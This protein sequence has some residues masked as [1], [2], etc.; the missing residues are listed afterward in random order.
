MTCRLAADHQNIFLWMKV[1]LND[2]FFL[3]KYALSIPSSPNAIS[4]LPPHTQ[5]L[6]LFLILNK[7][8]I[9]ILNPI[10]KSSFVF[11]RLNKEFGNRQSR[12]EL[13][14]TSTFGRGIF[15]IK[16][17]WSLVIRKITHHLFC[18]FSHF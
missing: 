1:I 9:Y 10:Y 8:K 12:V 17:K 11:T 18:P 5:H 3:L 14:I 13:L 6:Y 15:T 4:K 16:Q 2:Y 7:A